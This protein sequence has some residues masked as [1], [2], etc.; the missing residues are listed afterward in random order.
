MSATT[1]AWAGVW[2]AR[3]LVQASYHPSPYPPA[4]I[5][6]EAP[7]SPMRTITPAHR[8]LLPRCPSI[9]ASLPGILLPYST[10]TRRVSRRGPR[11]L[12]PRRVGSEVGEAV[13][14]PRSVRPA[15]INSV[16]STLMTGPPISLTAQPVSSSTRTRVPARSPPRM[17]V[18][19]QVPVVR[20]SLFIYLDSLTV[21]IM[22]DDASFYSLLYP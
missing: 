6:M 15:R 4:L 20:N 1:T 3:T 10:R 9:L 22:L 17:I 8:L 21:S 16:S 5:A 18:G 14:L 12:A 11:R 2:A 7:A 19:E 13:C